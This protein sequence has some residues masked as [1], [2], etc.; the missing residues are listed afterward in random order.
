MGLLDNYSRVS[1]IGFP[2]PSDA[3]QEIMQMLAFGFNM[4]FKAKGFWAL[5]E[6][7]VAK[8]PEKAPDVVFFRKESGGKE[9]ITFIEITTKAELKKIIKASQK[10]IERLEIRNTIIKEFL[11][12]FISYF[13][14][15]R[16][17]YY[18]PKDIGRRDLY[19][20]SQYLNSIPLV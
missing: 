7:A 15:V 8:K 1:G 17:L 5:T 18:C 3:H 19:L 6:I 13:Q 20:Y 9:A 10:L 12:F 16:F 2:R 11:I 14:F 4:E